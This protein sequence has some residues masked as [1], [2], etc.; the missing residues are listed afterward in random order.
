MGHRFKIAGLAA[1]VIV[2][3]FIFDGCKGN[4]Q[5]AEKPQA[6]PQKTETPAQ[7]AT[8]AEPAS[9]NPSASTVQPSGAKGDAKAGSAVADTKALLAPKKL[10][11]KAPDSYK[12]K[13]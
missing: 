6:E 4:E 8:P 7:T 12:V 9:A 5:Q 13:F 10:T 3:A 11:E 2:A 1:T